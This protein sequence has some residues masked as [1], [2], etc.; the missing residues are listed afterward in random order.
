MA[1]SAGGRVGGN[2][3]DPS[4][5]LCYA[6]AYKISHSHSIRLINAAYILEQDENIFCLAYQPNFGGK[7]GVRSLRAI[8]P[9]ACH[10]E[11]PHRV[12]SQQ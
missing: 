1:N 12:P 10:I 9:S 2:A 7:G 6:I 3:G 5:F 8:Y 11:L 4:G